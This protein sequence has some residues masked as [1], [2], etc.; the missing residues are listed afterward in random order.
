M[1]SGNKWDIYIIIYI[2][3]YIPNEMGY[4]VPLN[5]WIPSSMAG[6]FHDFS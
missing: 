2:Y 4:G 6:I 3:I 1:I 5:I